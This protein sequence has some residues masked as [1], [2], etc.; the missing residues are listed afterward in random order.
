M[1]N[2]SKQLLA[3]KF[4]ENYDINDHFLKFDKNVRDLKAIGATMEEVDIVCHLLL[5]LPKFFDNLITALETIDPA[6]LSLEF[7]KSRIL[8]ENS[9][10]N[11][12]KSNGGSRLS[13][14]SSA[15]YM[16]N[17]SKIIC[18]HCGKAGHIKL[19]CFALKNKRKDKFR[20]QW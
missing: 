12:T 18:Y 3:M 8:D 11:A 9:K 10:R 7:V 5:T 16:K 6:N 4:D 19:K 14:E 1:Y 15:M 17:A 20:Q 2:L 13:N